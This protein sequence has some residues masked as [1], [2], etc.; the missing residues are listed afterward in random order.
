M[1]TNMSNHPEAQPRPAPMPSFDKQY[2][3]ELEDFRRTKAIMDRDRE[4][5]EANRRKSKNEKEGVERKVREELTK[6]KEAIP[7]SDAIAAE[8]CER[9]ASGELLTVMC[10]DEHLPTVKRCNQWLRENVDFRI[11][12]EQSI[13]DRL[14]IFEE[15]TIQIP[16]EAV[17]DFVEV[18]KGNNVQRTLNS[19]RSQMAKL[20]VD[21]RFRHL[22]ALRP[23]RW[24]D[25]QTII[26]KEGDGFDP[27]NMSAEDLER[28]IAEIEKKS[29]C[30]RAVA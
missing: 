10:L 28:H 23:Q 8:I 17:R 19:N 9:I 14:F 29:R 30:V 13:Q 3:E 5:W 15:Q 27:A 1:S 26:S 7:Y 6:R 24:G 20:Q 12:Y 22:K 16:D 18:K 4:E 2:Q 21:V 25:V 11:L